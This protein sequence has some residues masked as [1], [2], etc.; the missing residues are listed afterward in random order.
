MGRPRLL[1]LRARLRVAI[2]VSVAMAWG[3]QDRQWL[4][5]TRE[6]Q[7]KRRIDWKRWYRERKEEFQVSSK[8]LD[9]SRSGPHLVVLVI[10]VN[11]VV[12]SGRPYPKGHG[13]GQVAPGDRSA[14]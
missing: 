7:I 5:R 11:G 6:Q 14:G 13:K 2:L 9:L 10:D 12:R 1:Q 4:A 8:V 3:A